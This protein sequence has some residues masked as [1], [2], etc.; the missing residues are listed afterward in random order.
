LLLFGEFSRAF[1]LLIRQI[2]VYWKKVVND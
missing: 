2:N 1:I